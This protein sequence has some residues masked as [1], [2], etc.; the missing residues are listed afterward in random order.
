MPTHRGDE[1]LMREDEILYGKKQAPALM[2]LLD[3]LSIEVNNKIRMRGIGKGFVCVQEDFNKLILQADKKIFWAT[4]EKDFQIRLNDIIHVQTIIKNI[5]IDI[6]FMYINK[7]LTDGQ[8]GVLSKITSKIETQLSNWNKVTDKK[9]TDNKV[10]SGQ[11][12]D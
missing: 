2:K 10:M 8:V 3:E 11:G 7:A 4:Q 9:V 5:W 12:S 1:K 6:R